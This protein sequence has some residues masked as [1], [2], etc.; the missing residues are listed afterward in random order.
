M[1]VRLAGFA[2]SVKSGGAGAFM[3]RLMGILRVNPPPTPVIATVAGP[4]VAALEAV[5]V[6]TLLVPVAGFTLKLAVTPAG[7]PVALRATE[8]VKP[9]VRVMVTVLVPL[10]PRLTVRLA[11]LAES[12]KSGVAG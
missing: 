9:P 7:N 8:L 5:S 10:A 4:V 2:E 12:A 11:G 6:N 1:I 3:V